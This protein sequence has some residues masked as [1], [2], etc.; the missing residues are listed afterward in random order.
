[1]AIVESELA[2][3]NQA[4]H[5]I[6]SKTPDLPYSFVSPESEYFYAELAYKIDAMLAL[7]S[8]RAGDTRYTHF[9]VDSDF[10]K[11]L[12]EKTRI[13]SPLRY[14]ALLPFSRV[15]VEGH[16]NPDADADVQKA[17]LTPVARVVSFTV[18]PFTETQ[19]MSL[20]YSLFLPANSPGKIVS[21]ED[22]NVVI[23]NN[24]FPYLSL[25][26]RT[27]RDAQPYDLG[28]YARAV[29]A[30][31][32]NI[33]KPYLFERAN[34]HCEHP[35]G[36][37][38]ADIEQLTIDHFTPKAIARLHGWPPSRVESPANLQLLCPLHHK[39]KDGKTPAKKAQVVFQSN[40]GM[41]RYS[42]HV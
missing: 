30:G 24:M 16:Y 3:K 10:M 39:E 34:G 36:C 11:G 14:A 23:G 7:Q 31:Y 21:Y 26:E 18:I 35:K 4:L 6:G 33:V 2:R 15:T 12:R 9:H 40:G 5:N 17:K 13:D 38:V 8:F 32:K 25:G 29:D 37:D 28:V 1:M 19:D 20:V 27:E 22:P 41:I 42:E